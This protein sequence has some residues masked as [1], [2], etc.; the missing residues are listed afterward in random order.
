MKLSQDDLDL[1]LWA[2]AIGPSSIKRPGD[3]DRVNRLAAIIR[4]LT[5]PVCG[6]A[7]SR[8]RSSYV[9]CVK[10][11]GHEDNHADEKGRWR[12]A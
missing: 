9:N 2:E 7:Y 1:V 3:A 4:R 11:D 5:S 10:P 6:Y 8:G 12:D